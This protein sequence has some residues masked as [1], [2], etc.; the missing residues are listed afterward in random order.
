MIIVKNLTKK[1]N[2]SK[3]KTE[4]VIA[5]NDISLVLPDKGF[6]A[7]YGA[8]GCGKSTLLNV[9]GG[10]D[11]ADMGEMIVNGRST[12]GFNQHDWNSYRNQEV[13][14]VFQ[15]YFLLPHLNVFDNIAVTL[16]MS[17]QTDNLE[18]KIHN[19]L[20]QVDLAKYGKRYPRQLSGGQQQRVAIARAL[21]ANPSII[22][23]DEPTGALD[24]KS[25]KMVMKT[26][27]DISK[28]HLVVM[29]THNE[30]MAKEYAD[31]LI[32]ISYGSIISD[33]N[34][35]KVDE[36][37]AT[38]KAD[39]PEVHLPFKTSIKWSLR[40][41]VKKKSRSIP[42]AIASGIGLAAA[43]IVLSMT[44]G[45]NEFVKI[46][47]KNAIKDY[48]VYVT[49]HSKNSSESN[50]ANLIEFPDT[51]DIVI[52]KSDY[53]AQEH[54]ITMQK[55][56]IDYMQN[57]LTPNVD[58]D[59][60]S[61]NG[62]IGFNL[63]SK[64]TAD[65]Y[66]KVDT[67]RYLTC[68][69]PTTD[70]YDFLINDQYDVI[71]SDDGSNDRLPRNK[72]ELTL[73]V[74]TYNRIDL[75]ALQKMGFDTS[76]DS[77]KASDVVGTKKYRI[78]SNDDFY[79]LDNKEVVIDGAT[80]NREVYRPY[81]TSHYEELYN[82]K[83]EIELTIVSIIRP[84]EHNNNYIYSNCLLYHPDLSKYLTNETDGLNTKSE[85]VQAQINN[86]E[87]DVVTGDNFD[88]IYMSNY[89]ITPQYQRESRLVELGALERVTSY[90][91]Y[92]ENFEQRDTII[93][94]AEKYKVDPDS[95]IIIK[96]K[97]YLES[98]TSSFSSLV[99]TFSIILLMFSLVSILVAA[100]MTAILTY[101]SVIERKREIGLL[102][103]LGAR[104]VDVSL[105]FIS[106]A[107]L[108]G[109]AAGVLGIGL[110]YAFA[111]LVSRVVVSLIDVYNSK[112]L[113]PSPDQFSHV[114]FWLI[115]V[116]FAA[117]I[118]IGIIASLVP[119]IIAGNKKPAEALKE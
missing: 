117:A 42:I 99:R 25:S 74:D 96:T 1:Y 8:S 90:F 103:S 57:G 11:Q 52:E 21:I 75:G 115:P 76:G 51:A 32:E 78:V 73:V 106:E 18:E 101:I 38:E 3:D 59:H 7:I 23:T 34:P 69:S 56:F 110:C 88:T 47:Q 81:G 111:P 66:L 89:E 9:L 91:Y 39:L 95:N 65:S 108:I 104:Q 5:L 62:T 86:E 53:K 29:V 92:T 71:A 45:I 72:N 33:S 44:Q 40:N 54:Y 87:W 17:K 41:V 116:L 24:E 30:R 50:E 55:D 85:V 12:N 22:L 43:G 37:V 35:L 46:A 14:F 84:K 119:A 48:P 107:S 6:V 15:N 118:A 93:K 113:K 60:F 80:I 28:D 63:F 64:P 112:M 16:Q 58:Y 67:T 19:A 98:V 20:N 49:C 36:V 26:L 77:I 82:D 79:Y 13:G 2:S 109:I 102:R 83:S 4:E 68:I 100:I 97:D 31:R 10:L 70:T 105:M 27:K 114:Q 94:Y 61:T